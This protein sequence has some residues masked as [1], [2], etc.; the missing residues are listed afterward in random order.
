MIFQILVWTGK[1]LR[2]N[3]IRNFYIMEALQCI[4]YQVI[5]DAA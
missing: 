1:Y 4:K 2:Y 3:V 5:P